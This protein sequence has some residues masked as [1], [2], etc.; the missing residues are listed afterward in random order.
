MTT[1]NVL[2]R[3]EVNRSFS[4]YTHV[5]TTFFGVMKVEN[6]KRLFLISA[7]ALYA[8]MTVAMVLQMYCPGSITYKILVPVVLLTSI[9]GCIDGYF[10]LSRIYD[11]APTG[12]YKLF[13]N[14]VSSSSK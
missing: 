8:I 6:V 2:S 1:I 7:L 3:G 12:C 4:E 9:V 13:L 11:M 10:S 14:I 5:T